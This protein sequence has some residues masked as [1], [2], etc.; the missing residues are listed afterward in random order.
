MDVQKSLISLGALG[1]IF[2]GINKQKGFVAIAGLGLLFAFVGA[3]L[4]VAYNNMTTKK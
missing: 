3:G 4:G 2:Y 1:G